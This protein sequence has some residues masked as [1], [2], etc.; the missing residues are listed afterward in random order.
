MDYRSEKLISLIRDSAALFLKA[1][2]EVPPGTLLTVTRAELSSDE[3]YANV[4]VSVFPT[5]RIGVFLE[6]FKFLQSEFNDY[7]RKEMRLR[8]VPA[9]RFKLDETELK[10]E[11]IG[12]LLE[13]NKE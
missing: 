11:R 3:Q 13:E 7:A 2:A 6:K 8:Y 4:F 1:H 5:D 12:K 10:S 9:I